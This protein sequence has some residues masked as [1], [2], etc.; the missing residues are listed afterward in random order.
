VSVVDLI[1]KDIE[2]AIGPSQP[3]FWYL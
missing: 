1:S 2:G 3:A